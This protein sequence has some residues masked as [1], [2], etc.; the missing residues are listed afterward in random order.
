MIMCRIRVA[1]I[2]DGVYEGFLPLP[3][4]RER[5]FVHDGIIEHD[6]CKPTLSHGTV[7]AS[8]M[9]CLCEKVE[10][11]SIKVPTKLDWVSVQSICDAI[12]W[13]SQHEIKM[14][15]FS[16][17]ITNYFMGMKVERAAK[18]YI[19][20]G[21]VVVASYSNESVPS[22]PAMCND[23][24]GVKCSKEDHAELLYYED[25]DIW[26]VRAPSSLLMMNGGQVYTEG[27]NS[28]ATP[29]LSA[30]IAEYLTLHPSAVSSDIR[31]L[32]LQ[33]A[34]INRVK[35]D[36][37]VFLQKW[38]NQEYVY[39]ICVYGNINL[40]DEICSRLCHTYSVLRVCDDVK[41]DVDLPIGIYS[42]NCSEALLGLLSAIY[43]CDVIVIYRHSIEVQ[44]CDS[45]F[46]LSV[47]AD[48]SDIVVVLQD[49]SVFFANNDTYWD[50]LKLIMGYNS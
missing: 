24:F 38:E 33:K 23:V 32:L 46:D 3:R 43:A 34:E 50:Q 4:V 18:A 5:L 21:G 29:V 9:G 16:L 13:C 49:G 17:A 20:S 37:R 1:V 11:I 12:D 36:R 10:V 47:S 27:Y 40:F 31:L 14:I 41:T 44:N 25:E 35:N 28:N 22:W 19:S 45:G 8:I 48:G 30:I 42:D 6:K 39:T 7:C 26:G 15:Q 2:D